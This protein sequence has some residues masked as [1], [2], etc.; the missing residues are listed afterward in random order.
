M[1]AL[2]FD[3]GTSTAVALLEGRAIVEVRRFELPG[4]EHPEGARWH[5]WATW[6]DFLFEDWSPEAVFFEIPFG[7][8]AKVLKIQFA[9]CTM[10][11]LVS[12]RRGVDYAGL[13]PSDVK[14]FATG[15]GNSGK[16]AMREALLER[17]DE[18][19]PP[20]DPEDMS[21][22]EI[23]ATWLAALARANLIVYPEEKEAAA[24]LAG[25]DS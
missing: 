12:H 22:D 10:V 2:A 14:S 25:E 4:P 24:L 3:L 19:R 13:K 7:R 17:R 11:E 5:A 15:K 20:R 9:M 16:P 8:Y 23:D 21:E 18:I 1:R 6:L